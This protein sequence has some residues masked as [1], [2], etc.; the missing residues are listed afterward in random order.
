M[1]GKEPELWHRKGAPERWFCEKLMEKGGG[2]P[3]FDFAIHVAQFVL[4]FASA[5]AT[6]AAST[7]IDA[8]LVDCFTSRSAGQ[9]NEII[10]TLAIE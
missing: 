2:L 7:A 10:T 1:P 6:G 8:L 5:H 3:P 4:W 9:R